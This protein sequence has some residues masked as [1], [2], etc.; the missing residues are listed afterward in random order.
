MG[1]GAGHWPG[2]GA[3]VRATRSSTVQLTAH[4]RGDCIFDV[5]TMHM[6]AHGVQGCPFT[7]HGAK[8]WQWGSAHRRLQT[9]DWL[10]RRE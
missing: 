6:A 3:E 2:V 8:A 10:C 9:V 5:L 7:R 4:Q 1:K